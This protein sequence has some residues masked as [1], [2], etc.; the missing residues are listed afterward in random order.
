M[1]QIP[2]GAVG[3]G[4]S[5]FKIGSQWD[6]YSRKQFC[7]ASAADLA[8]QSL[9]LFDIGIGSN[10][11]PVG[12]TVNTT[13][14]V[15]VTN[16]DTNLD[17]PGQMPFDFYSI[18]GI[19]LQFPNTQ[20]TP[21]TVGGVNDKSFW[22]SVV[23]AILYDSYC[24]LKIN[25]TEFLRCLAVD[26]PCAGGPSGFA[27]MGTTGALTVGASQGAITN[28]AP[29]VNNFL[30]FGQFPLNL[31]KSDRVKFTLTFGP[32]MVNQSGTSVYKPSISAAQPTFIRAIL[33]G[34]KLQA[35]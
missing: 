14:Q 16:Q 26:I 35:A 31:E 24:T 20:L 18:Q 1:L 28:G 10:Y 12:G 2:A 6:V 19:A 29:F 22:P 30:S 34:N 27:A 5:G 15:N 11:L 32:S 33:K 21:G 17:T 3:P 7:L 13:P 8:G 4:A 23:E 25:D 9:T